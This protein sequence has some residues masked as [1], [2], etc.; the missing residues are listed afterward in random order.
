M[1]PKAPQLETILAAAV[2]ISSADERCAFVV[3]ACGSDLELKRRVEQMI[4]D[5]F[6]AGSFLEVPAPAFTATVAQPSDERPGE[7]IGPYKLL[8][9]I[10]EGGMGIV[11]M[12]EQTQP[13]QR[14]VAVKIIKAGMDTRQVIARFEAERQALALMDHP[15]IAKVFDAGTTDTGRSYFVMELVK[16]TSIINY[17]DEHRLTPR[18]RLEL[19][20]P[21]CQAIQHAHQKGIIHRDIKPSNILVAPNDGKPVVKVIDFGVAKATGQRLTEM[22]LFTQIGAVVGTLEYMSPE[23]AELNNQDIDTRSDIYSLGVLLYE[24]LTGTTPLSRDRLKQAAFTEMLRIIREEEPPKPSTRLSELSSHHAPR[25]EPGLGTRSVPATLASVSAQRHTDPAK[26]TKLVRGELDWIVM[27]ALEKDRNRRY[28]TANGF[29]M[30]VQRY[31]ADEPV[32][33]CP[34]SVG[35]RLRKFVRRNQSRL[36]VAAALVLLLLSAGVFAWHA[37]RQAAQRRAEAQQRMQEDL[38]RHG[39]NAEAVAALLD[40]CE[41]ALRTDQADR[42]ALALGVAERRAADGGAEDLAARLDR[43]RADLGLLRELD[44][45][46]TNMWTWTDV[47]SLDWERNNEVHQA[48]F[49]A[50]LA[51]YGVA[52]GGT[53]PAEAAGRINESLIR[54]RALRALDL[55]LALTPSSRDRAAG[56]PDRV[57]VREVLRSADPDPYRTAVRTAVRTFD[58][59]AVRGDNAKFAELIG[60]PQ[61]LDQPARYAAVLGRIQSLPPARRRAILASALKTRPGDLSLLME[62]GISYPAERRDHEGVRERVRWFQAA[63]AAHPGN[64]AAHNQLG[65]ALQHKGDLAEAVAELRKAVALE[66][67]NP[68]GYYYLGNALKEGGT[69]ASAD[70]AL[71]H[72]QTAVK[73]APEQSIPHVSLGMAQFG[74]GKRDEGIATLRRAVELDENSARARSALGASLFLKGERDAAVVQFREGARRNPENAE[75]QYGFG[76][77]LLNSNG[78]LGEAVAAIKKAVKLDPKSDLAHNSLARVLATG[79]DWVRDRVLAVAH[80]TQACKLTDGKNPTY[81]ATLAAAHAEAGNFDKAVEFQKKAL[82]D[83]AY[84]KQHGSVG[85]ER[86]QLYEQKKPYRDPALVRREVAP[87]PQEVKPERR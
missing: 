22:T 61:A 55:W 54:D 1:D 47:D 18:E 41:D 11:W 52:A 80:A 86:L 79:P 43:C 24:L 59:T 9:R 75:V 3:Q 81:L 87:P 73:L 66:P 77:A 30:D 83:L 53:P 7:R 72:L 51:R 84:A 37:D 85:R 68:E 67:K 71:V 35:Y 49:R 32:L 50:A 27:K 31:L 36:A 26:L 20:L 28:E 29:A 63:V 14:K 34:P 10:G 60:Q 64:A 38:A 23:Q 33:A 25:D 21:V 2:E 78:D 8:E 58:R 19:F 65:F 74:M 17:C 44:A 70:E 16:G 62:M 82:D 76:I 56:D 48:R 45:A 5:H 40:Q 12:A 57:W 46:D 39:R 4:A 15:N 69:K 6:Q 13:V 42:A